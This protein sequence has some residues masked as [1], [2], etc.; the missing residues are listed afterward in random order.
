MVGMRCRVCGESGS[1][2]VAC[3][4]F[5]RNY[6][7][8]SAQ[9]LPVNTS[10]NNGI[11]L[12]V[13]PI[14]YPIVLPPICDCAGCCR[15]TTGPRSWPPNTPQNNSIVRGVSTHDCTPTSL[16]RTGCF[17]STTDRRSWPRA[18]SGGS[19]CAA[20]ALSLH[21]G[22]NAWCESGDLPTNRSSVCLKC[23]NWSVCPLRAPHAAW[24]W[25]S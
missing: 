23:Q 8:V 15:S 1:D 2:L 11:V 21:L 18:T 12:D 20:G 10:Q 7:W 9:T 6:T 17:R 22:A 14:V 25:S 3:V 4:A 13:Y 19:C 16:S 24:I 5:Q